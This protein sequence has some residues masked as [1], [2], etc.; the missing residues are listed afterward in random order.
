MDSAKFSS[1]AMQ[2]KSPKLEQL[3]VLFQSLGTFT[4]TTEGLD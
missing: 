4:E 3:T 2:E 1:N